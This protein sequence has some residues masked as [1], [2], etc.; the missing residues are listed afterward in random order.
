MNRT[1]QVYEFLPVMLYNNALHMAAAMLLP[2]FRPR[3]TIYG[4]CVL[5]MSSLDS[6]TLTNPTG[7]PMINSGCN[8]CFDL[9][10]KQWYHRTSGAHNISITG[11]AN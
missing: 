1:Y 11:T 10:D 7:T 6:T 9:F 4:T 5:K 3:A 2:P 8:P